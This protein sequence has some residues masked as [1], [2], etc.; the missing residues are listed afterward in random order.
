[1]KLFLWLSVQLE[2]RCLGEGGVLLSQHQLTF[3]SVL[4]WEFRSCSPLVARP[5]AQGFAAGA[6]VQ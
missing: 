3:A 6:V 5:C 2:S 1:M 4:S